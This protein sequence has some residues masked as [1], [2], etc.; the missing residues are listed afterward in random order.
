[1]SSPGETF[2][3]PVPPPSEAGRPEYEFGPEENR[4]ITDLGAKMQFVGSLTT[5]LGGA[6]VLYTG[7][8]GGGGGW[9]RGAR[10]AVGGGRGAG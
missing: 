3:A 9:G 8:V 2:K 7:Y 10:G 6:L 5:L 1:M 4:T